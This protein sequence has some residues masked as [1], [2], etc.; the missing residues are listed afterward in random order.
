MDPAE[1]AAWTVVANVLLNL[2]GVLTQ[3]LSRHGPIA[4]C[5]DWQLRGPRPAASSSRT[6]RPASARSRWR[7]CSA[8]TAGRRRAPPPRRPTTR[9]RPRPPHFAPKAKHVIYL[10]MSGAP[11]Q[12]DLFDYKPELVK[13]HM[14]PCPDELLKNQRFAFIKGHPKLL[15]TPYKFAQYGQSGAWVSELLPHF[16][17]GRRRRRDHQVDVHRPVQPRPGRAVPLHRLA[18]QRRGGDGL[19]DHL[20]PR[21]R[22]PGPARLRRAD[23]RRHRPD[24][25]QGALEHR[26]PADASTRACSAAPPATRSSTSANPK[27]MD[28]DA[29]RRSLDAL[30]QAQRVRAE[31]SSATP[32]R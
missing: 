15:G 4:T 24:R 10:H 17:G 1:L 18:A 6:R 21:L 3:G 19:V 26:L 23:Q 5:H 20:R 27:G 12:H 14:Q 32:R 7:R 31:A 2:D 16:S 9:W 13:H 22:E 28:R 11:P 29:R 30:R 8:A 25:R